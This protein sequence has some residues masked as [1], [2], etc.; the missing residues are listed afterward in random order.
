MFNANHLKKHDDIF[1]WGPPSLLEEPH[2]PWMI[3]LTTAADALFVYCLLLEKDFSAIL[4]G[5]ILVDEGICFHSLQPLPSLP[6]PLSI[7][8]V[9]AV[10]PICVRDY[11]FKLSDYHTYVQE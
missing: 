9:Y 2:C 7:R 3:A 10:A 6:V 11:Q 8:T 1:F 5:Y 4:L